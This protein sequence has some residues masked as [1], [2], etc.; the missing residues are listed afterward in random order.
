MLDTAE[1]IRQY[2]V[3]V[4]AI[5]RPRTEGGYALISGHRRRVIFI[6]LLTSGQLPAHLLEIDTTAQQQIEAIL[7][8]QALDL[9]PHKSAC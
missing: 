6:N 4:P 8:Y 3:L 9:S 1:S 2:G 7:Y 5:A